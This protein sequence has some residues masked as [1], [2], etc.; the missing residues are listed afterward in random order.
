MKRFKRRSLQ[1]ARV[2]VVK[3]D[4]KACGHGYRLKYDSSAVLNR[5][6]PDPASPLGNS[7]HGNLE[8]KARQA[9]SVAHVRSRSD[10]IGM[11]RLLC[12]FVYQLVQS[13]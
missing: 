1:R 4:S 3:S 2:S 11:L 9:L 8:H 5:R 10:Q 6:P 12:S 7:V 13:T